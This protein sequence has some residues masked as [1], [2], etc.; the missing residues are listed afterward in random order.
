MKEQNLQCLG[1]VVAL[2]GWCG[3]V[4]IKNP[5]A[6][7]AGLFFWMISAFLLTLW[8]ARTGARWIA[9]QNAVNLCFAVSAFCAIKGVI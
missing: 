5:Q 9:L 7:G 8:G 3:V 6:V 2:I 4:Q 1:V